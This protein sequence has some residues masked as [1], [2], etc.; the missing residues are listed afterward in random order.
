MNK[1]LPEGVFVVVGASASVY[2][3]YSIFAGTI[4]FFQALFGLVVFGAVGY[5]AYVRLK[6]K[7]A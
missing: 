3:V 2:A 7:L 6:K 5:Y 1:Y 4:P